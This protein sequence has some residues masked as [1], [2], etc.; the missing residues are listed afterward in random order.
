MHFVYTTVTK[1]DSTRLRGRNGRPPWCLDKRVNL[2]P[3]LLQMCLALIL[4]SYV[5]PVAAAC[6][7]GLTEPCDAF[8]SS[9]EFQNKRDGMSCYLKKPGETGLQ[10]SFAKSAVAT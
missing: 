3:H 2:R 6:T 10:Q 1:E 9:G 4:I 8:A 7:A 5:D